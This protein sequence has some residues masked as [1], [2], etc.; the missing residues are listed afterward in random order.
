MEVP[1]NK[2]QELYFATVIFMLLTIHFFGNALDYFAAAG[3]IEANCRWGCTS[4]EEEL[5]SE[6]ETSGFI[7]FITSV[8]MAGLAFFFWPEKTDEEREK[9]KE[10]CE[11]N[12]RNIEAKRRKIEAERV[13][14]EKELLDQKTKLRMVERELF[15]QAFI[16][17]EQTE[18]SPNQINKYKRYV[19]W[20]KT[21][22]NLVA[23]KNE[24][25]ARKHKRNFE[26]YLKSMGA[27][28]KSGS[29]E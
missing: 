17:G 12:R 10:I 16:S 25:I 22:E 26:E 1:E 4:L 18:I 11:A 2:N 14:K 7:S 27:E 6:I 20:A 8:I 5:I 9:E 29:E 13:E 28:E 3:E 23:D 21:Q 19:E 15:Q 24:Y